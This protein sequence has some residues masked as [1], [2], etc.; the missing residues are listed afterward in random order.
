MPNQQSLAPM[1][2]IIRIF[3]NS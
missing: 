1:F 3:K 2:V